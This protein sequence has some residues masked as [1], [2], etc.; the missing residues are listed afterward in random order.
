[1]FKTYFSL[2]LKEI[3]RLG[4]VAESSLSQS[5]HM[6]HIQVIEESQSK[7]D[8]V[9]GALPYEDVT[10]FKTIKDVEKVDNLAF[11]W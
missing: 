6:Y 3:R 9:P 10:E 2:D 7:Q 8:Q 4:D 5:E 1:M 11:I